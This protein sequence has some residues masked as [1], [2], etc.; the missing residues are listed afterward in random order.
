VPKEQEKGR[1]AGP[2][3][4]WSVGVIGG[5]YLID[6]SEDRGE[7]TPGADRERVYKDQ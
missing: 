2:A 7:V 3:T 6:Q 1:E 5:R 4:I